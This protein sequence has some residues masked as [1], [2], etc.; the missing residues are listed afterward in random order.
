MSAGTCPAQY[1]HGCRPGCRP[2][3]AGSPQPV[4]NTLPCPVPPSCRAPDPARVLCTSQP[5]LHRGTRADWGGGDLRGPRPR[6]GALDKSQRPPHRGQPLRQTDTWSTA[7]GQKQQRQD[8]ESRG[9]WPCLAGDTGPGHRGHHVVTETRRVCGT[10]KHGPQAHT[11]TMSWPCRPARPFPRPP[12]W[13]A[14]RDF[15]RPPD[16]KQDLAGIWGHG[17]TAPARVQ[18][19]RLSRHRLRV[20][21]NCGLSPPAT[22]RAPGFWTQQRASSGGARSHRRS[23]REAAL[24]AFLLPAPAPRASCRL[25]PPAGPSGSHGLPASQPRSCANPST[26]RGWHGGVREPRCPPW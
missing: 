5:W 12:Q 1:K 7:E 10:G 19:N 26:H 23:P 2:R 18:K 4:R 3:Q 15:K 14:G 16:G 8:P 20:A 21:P 22:S 25:Q 17:A 9:A 11:V 13:P 6:C 24:L